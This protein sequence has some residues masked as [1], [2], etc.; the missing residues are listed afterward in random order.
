MAKETTVQNTHR[1][2]K[3]WWRRELS[4]GCHKPGADRLRGQEDSVGRR[5]SRLRHCW[6]QELASSTWSDSLGQI[7]PL[8]PIKRHQAVV[9]A[10]LGLEHTEWTLGQKKEG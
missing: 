1:R 10:D 8:F 4:G 2:V 7:L 5:H 6:G 3:L 9:T